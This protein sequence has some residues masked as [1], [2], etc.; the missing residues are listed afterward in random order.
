MDK[1]KSSLELL[2][3]RH[4][5]CKSLLLVDLLL[6][7]LVCLSDPGNDI[8]VISGHT[9]TSGCSLNLLE[10]LLHVVLIYSILLV[11]AVS[12]KRRGLYDLRVIRLVR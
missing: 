8:L 7:L 11:A 3:L 2:P 12:R 10:F 4:P 5:L 9:A 1:V 6:V